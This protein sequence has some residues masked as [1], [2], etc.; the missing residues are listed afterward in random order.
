MSTPSSPTSFNQAAEA[1]W[2]GNLR[3]AARFWEPLRV[4]YN[5]VLIG[6]V[7]AWVI[8]TWPHFQPAL[9]LATLVPMTFLA[10]MANACYSAAYLVD[11]PL[12]YGP[13]QLLA[14]WRWTGWTVGTMFAILLANYW[15]ADEIF[16]DVH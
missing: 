12:Q 6:T 9:R 13:R 14:C 2:R 3:Q 16:P 11:V 7:V 15:I 8:A 4:G 5:M 1:S 10:F